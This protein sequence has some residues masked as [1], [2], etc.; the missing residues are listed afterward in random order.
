MTRWL[1]LY[2]IQASEANR[3][4]HVGHRADALPDTHLSSR[5]NRRIVD[6]D[7]A[8]LTA[9]A[10]MFS[11]KI[12]ATHIFGIG[13]DSDPEK[14]TVTGKKSQGV[15]RLIRGSHAVN[16]A[17][18]FV[19]QELVKDSILCHCVRP[20]SGVL[21]AAGTAKISGAGK[22]AHLFLVDPES[23]IRRPVIV[24]ALGFGTGLERDLDT[25]Y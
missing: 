16:I 13:L 21:G 18:L 1:C 3:V 2:R 20:P 15:Q 5:G 19:N 8:V 14:E 6:F 10:K 17:A 22:S 9:V 25:L 23:N 11:K 24:V 7:V 4:D 12:D